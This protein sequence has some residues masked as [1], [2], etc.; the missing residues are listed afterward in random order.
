M[1]RG[2]AEIITTFLFDLDGTLVETEQLKAL[3]YARAVMALRPGVLERDVLDAFKAVVG[4]S[5]EEVSAAL[6]TRF[7]LSAAARARLAEW[8]VTQEWQVLA[9]MHVQ[10]YEAMLQDAA[11]IQ[12]YQYPHNIALL[13]WAHANRYQ[14]GLTT[15]SHREQA[16]RI[17]NVLGLR[18]LLDV[19]ATRE[20]VR[21]AK[22]DPEIY[23]WVMARLKVAPTA[24]IAVED[25]V[26]GVGAALAA[27]VSV[28]AVATMLTGKSLHDAAILPL[29]HIV[30][31]PSTVSA[32][33]ARILQECA[34]ASPPAP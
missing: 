33:V 10:A 12:R 30:D 20:D 13:R 5:R 8:G 14:T 2:A 16:Y 22:P 31:D 24:C 19:I 25:S 34:A 4:R 26:A 29:D 11:L 32:V 3:S 6:I 7:A 23:Q 17:L 9:Q 21:Q 28:I 1:A 15:M 27:G 18:D